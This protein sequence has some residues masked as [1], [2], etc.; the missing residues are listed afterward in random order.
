MPVGTFSFLGLVHP[1][2]ASD[3]IGTL[4]IET[5]E[6]HASTPGSGARGFPFLHFIPTM[7]A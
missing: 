5:N 6:L 3:I 7:G 1:L 4:I 2:P